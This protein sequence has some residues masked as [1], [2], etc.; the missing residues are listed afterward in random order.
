MIETASV[1][2]CRYN[3]ENEGRIPCVLGCKSMLCSQ[4]YLELFKSS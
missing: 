2:L 4:N 1:R 3:F